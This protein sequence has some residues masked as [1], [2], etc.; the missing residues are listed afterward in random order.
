MQLPHGPEDPQILRTGLGSFGGSHL[1][2][3]VGASPKS[4]RRAMTPSTAAA[5]SRSAGRRAEPRRAR[6]LASGFCGSR[7]RSG[8]RRSH[9]PCIHPNALLRVYGRDN[10]RAEDVAGLVLA[11]STSLVT[12]GPRPAFVFVQV[13]RWP[14]RRGCLCPIG[15]ARSRARAGPRRGLDLGETSHG[16]T[17]ID[18]L[19]QLCCGRSVTR[20]IRPPLTAERRWPA[21]SR[22]G[23][24]A[25]R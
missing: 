18:R 5:C 24:L 6:R 22:C 9:L 12:P 2:S 20:S 14:R 1:L 8:N 7:N 25:A 17:S 3:A 16:R 23:E 10:D 15:E 19:L 4:T 21:S 13:H 11:I